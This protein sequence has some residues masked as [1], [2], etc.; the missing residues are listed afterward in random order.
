M[1][2]MYPPPPFKSSWRQHP[3]SFV[4]FLL[5]TAFVFWLIFGY[6]GD[7]FP[8]IARAIN[9][10]STP[11]AA[12][13]TGTWI[14]WLI[15]GGYAGFVLS[16]VL[17][18]HSTITWLDDQQLNEHVKFVQRVRRSVPYSQI[19]GVKL[20]QSPLGRVFGYGTLTLERTGMKPFCMVNAQHAEELYDFFQEVVK[21]NKAHVRN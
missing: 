2:S 11:E 20:W 1:D 16:I 18:M 12:A 9:P 13:E 8:Q 17:S 15:A 4:P 5:A 19:D 14:A 6:M 10:E 21:R 3:V 7:A